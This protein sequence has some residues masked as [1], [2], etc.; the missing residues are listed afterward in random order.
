ML[1]DLIN[2][3][4]ME[5]NMKLVCNYVSKVW[6]NMKLMIFIKTCVLFLLYLFKKLY[7]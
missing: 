6:H 3:L 4:L 5:S 7:F 2:E 1:N